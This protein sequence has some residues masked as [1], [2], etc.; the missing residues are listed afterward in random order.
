MPVYEY[1]CLGCKKR[2]ELVETFAEHD[3]HKPGCVRCPHC[4]KR[5]GERIWSRVVA[6]TSKK[7]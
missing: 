1:R 6:V 5:K 7:S 4:G 3:K 2:F